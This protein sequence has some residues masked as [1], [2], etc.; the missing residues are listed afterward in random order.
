MKVTE[1]IRADGSIPFKE[2]FGKLNVQ[3]AAKVSVALVRMEQG[4]ESDSIP[5]F[6]L[7]ECK[8]ATDR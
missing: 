8:T 1:Y 2:W 3:A 5:S 6:A 7:S 4:I